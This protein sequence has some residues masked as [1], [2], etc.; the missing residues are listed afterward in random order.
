MELTQGV[1]KHVCV[2]VFV[3]RVL[4]GRLGAMS[5]SPHPC[6]VVSGIV[7]YTRHDHRRDF[8]DASLSAIAS[9]KV[10]GIPS[11]LGKRRKATEDLLGKKQCVV[12]R[13][14]L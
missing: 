12:W 7:R 8:I 1:D 10:P 9:E 3:C 6:Q 5:F 4:M 14:L 2:C 13:N 11:L